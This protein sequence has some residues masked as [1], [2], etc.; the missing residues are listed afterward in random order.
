MTAKLIDTHAH[1]DF[2]DYRE[3]RDRVIARA[4]ELC[5]AV[6]NIGVNLQAGRESLDLAHQHDFIYAGLGFHPHYCADWSPEAERELL[7][8]AADPRVVAIGEIGLDH[9]RDYGPHDVQEKVFRRMLGVVRETKKPV[10]LHIRAAWA[11][12]K[13][14]I[15]EELPTEHPGILHCFSGSLEDARWGTERGF[16]LGFNGSLTYPKSS[17]MS[18][19]REIPI[20]FAVLETDCPFLTPQSRRGKRNEPYYMREVAEILALAKQPLTYDDVARITTVNARRVLALPDQAQKQVVAYP[21][22]N[23]LYLNITNRCSNSCAFCVRTWSDFVKG[24]HLWLKHEPDLD[25]VLAAIGDPTPWDEIVFCGYGEPTERLDLLL[26]VAKGLKERGKR[27]RLNTNGQGDLING[28]N[29]VPE[30]V[31]CVDEVSVSLDVDTP[32]KYLE[33]CRPRYG[34]AAWPAMLEFIRHCRASLPATTVTALTMPDVDLTRCEAIAKE[35]DVRLR[36]REYMEV[37]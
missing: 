14:I 36:V 6:V 26:A 8:L 31:G 9:F 1:L 16:L 33:H 34:E 2:P 23:S 11:D 15:D 17:A 19:A 32:E 22:R 7:E 3:D 30:L 35:L 4:A 12:A 27:V 28:R 37:G 10:L 20:E 25:E 24:H 29:I 18:V 5:E 21:I 13:R